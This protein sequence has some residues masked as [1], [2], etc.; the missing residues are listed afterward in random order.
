MAQADSVKQLKIKTGVV[1]RIHKELVYY[2]KEMDKEQAKVEK[3]I[4]AGA[5][6]HDLKQAENVLQESAMMIPESRQRL[7]AALADLQSY[8]AENAEDVSGTEEETAAKDIIA[9][10][11]ALFSV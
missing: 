2:K 9:E 7:E 5:D 10:A 1:K 3:L 4:A 11:A 6:P 8:L